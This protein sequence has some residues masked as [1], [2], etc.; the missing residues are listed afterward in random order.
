LQRL[1][2]VGDFNDLAVANPWRKGMSVLAR[3][4]AERTALLGLAESAMSAWPAVK[5]SREHSR[6]S[7]TSNLISASRLPFGLIGGKGV[8]HRRHSD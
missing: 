1:L 2:R 6:L 3:D 7:H 4:G 8:V 5:I